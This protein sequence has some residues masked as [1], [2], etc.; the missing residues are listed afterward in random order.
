[1]VKL[2]LFDSLDAAAA[3]GADRLD[4]EHGVD[5]FHRL[6]WFRLVAEH[7]PLARI[8][9]L[10]AEIGDACAWLFLGIE[11]HTARV[12]GNWYTLDYGPIFVAADAQKQGALLNAL[13]RGLRGLGAA[14][15]ELDPLTHARAIGTA[16]RRSGWLAR[17]GQVSVRW[18]MPTQGLS[19][20]DYWGARPGQLRSTAARKGK[21]AKLDISII[22]H[23]DANAWS[24]YEQVYAGSWKPAEGSMPFLRALAQQEG[25]AGTLR[26]GIA[27]KDGR[28][29]AAQLWLTE[30]GRAT[31]HKL[32]YLSDA[33]ALSP[34]T[35]LG[36]AM[37][38]HALDVDRV[39]A[40]DF[41]LG[42]DTYKRDW[43]DRSEPV[44]RLVAFDL[45][46][47]AGLAALVG[48]LA[49]R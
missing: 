42:D 49:R 29:I 31:I 5:L 21:S 34:G 22:N 30:F 44:E 41:G 32:A 20:E 45:L 4:R 10:R 17:P 7:T 38:R 36:M 35:L 23:F 1:M 47:P 9:I 25:A 48:R 6:D 3:A 24:D 40:I 28:P 2:K 8:A 19:F 11:G 14:Q 15:V 39:D 27:R 18:V 12:L 33:R 26:L 16:L 13:A 46:R 43:I 37:F